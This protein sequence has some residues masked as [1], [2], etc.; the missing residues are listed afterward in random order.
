MLLNPLKPKSTVSTY[1]Y[2]GGLADVWP[3]V[4]PNPATP[5]CINNSTTV[6]HT[7]TPGAPAKDLFGLEVTQATP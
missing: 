5:A 6:C 7:F 1:T 2:H 4:T 3:K